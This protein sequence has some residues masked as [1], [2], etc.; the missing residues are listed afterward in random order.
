MHQPF[1]TQVMRARLR[2]ANGTDAN[3]VTWFV[4]PQNMDV[5]GVL[6]VDTWLQAVADDKSDLSR[7]QKI[8]RDR[9]KDIVD[10]C[11]IN[12]N[13][14]TD[15]AACAKQYPPPA[16]GGDARIAA[17]EGLTDNIR[18]CQLRALNRAD[19]KVTFTDAQ[20]GQL[21]AV[22]PHGVCDWTRPSVGYQ[23]SIPW[24]TY[25][26]GPGGKPLGPAPLSRSTK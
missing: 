8:I 1:Y 23:P 13:P 10:T 9:P 4:L 18:K 3:M 20:W 21:Q 6:A 2:A 26:G 12:S 25:A 5:D 22:F 19:Y 7:A 16:N 11:W 24:M 17:G 15:P 14:V